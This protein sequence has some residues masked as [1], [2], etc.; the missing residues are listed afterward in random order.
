MAPADIYALFG[1]ALE[2]ALEAVVSLDEPSRRTISLV[3][4]EV[5][6]VVS[7]HVENPYTGEVTLGED[8]LPQTTKASRSDHGLGARSM[9]RTVERYGGTLTTMAKDGIFHLNAM[10]PSPQ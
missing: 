3:V 2:N 4:R 7:I 5:A 1:N 8:G 10:L 6:G 9:R